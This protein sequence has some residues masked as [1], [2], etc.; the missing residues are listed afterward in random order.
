MSVKQKEQFLQALA[1]V[2][3]SASAVFSK[4]EAMQIAKS[5]GLKNPMWFFKE[6]K[7]GRNQF[8]PNM[9][10]LLSIG[11]T[12]VKPV[13]AEAPVLSIM[14]E[15]RCGAPVFHD[16]GKRY[17]KLNVFAPAGVIPGSKA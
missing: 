6:C 16:S 1:G 3:N 5:N 7:V 17:Q 10:T 8:S 4:T 2:N 13:A 11:N 12:A 14:I 9:A 15:S